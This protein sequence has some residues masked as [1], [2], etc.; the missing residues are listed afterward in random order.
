MCFSVSSFDLDLLYYDNECMTTGIWSLSYYAFMEMDLQYERRSRR[1]RYDY[2]CIM[3]RESGHCRAIP[4]CIIHDCRGTFVNVMF[5]HIRSS[6]DEDSG[7]N[8]AQPDVTLLEP[9]L[10]LTIDFLEMS[11]YQGARTTGE[12]LWSSLKDIRYRLADVE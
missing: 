7:L 12:G 2:L 3:H 8:L 5:V 10:S 1:F 9:C 4:G 11:I 6:K